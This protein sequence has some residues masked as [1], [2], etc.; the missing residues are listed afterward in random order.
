MTVT[1]I[2]EDNP[3]D[4]KSDNE[5]VALLGAYLGSRVFTFHI[6]KKE[7]P[8]GI[9]PTQTDQRYDFHPGLGS[10]GG[11]RLVFPLLALQPAHPLIVIDNPFLFRA[12]ICM[13]VDD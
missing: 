6:R 1:M 12:Y 10:A 13:N 5:K 4:R 2:K 3:G 11:L 7:T 8:H 9:A